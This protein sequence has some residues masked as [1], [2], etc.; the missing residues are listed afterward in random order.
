MSR[1][2]VES[3]AGL[4]ALCYWW[5]D[6]TRARNIRTQGSLDA[7]AQATKKKDAVLFYLFRLGAFE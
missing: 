1:E 5:P 2:R 4:S 3:G 7:V 6:P